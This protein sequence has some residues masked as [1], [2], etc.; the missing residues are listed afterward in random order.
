MNIRDV[1][2][3]AALLC[4]LVPFGFLVAGERS[5]TLSGPVATV[6]P[7]AYAEVQPG[8][9]ESLAIVSARNGKAHHFK[10][11]IVNTPMAMMQGLMFRSQMPKDH[12][13]L[14]V[15]GDVAPRAFWMKNTYIPLDIVFIAPDGRIRNVGYGK[16]ESLD[17][18]ASE[19]PVLHVLE[20]N[21]G[22]LKRLGLGAGDTVR[23]RAFGN[24]LE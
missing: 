19:G 16:P 23:H 9:T 13:M 3:V 17:P 4:F 6:K 10:V 11:E 22:T 7:A 24:A 12:G 2:G 21:A 8:P 5:A 15:F 18:V 1:M 14:F 20:L